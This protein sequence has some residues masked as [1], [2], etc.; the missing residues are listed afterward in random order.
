M[1]KGH[2]ET[3]KSYTPVRS[4][5]TESG[6][7]ESKSKEIVM[8]SWKHDKI[9]FRYSLLKFALITILVIIYFAYSL[10]FFLDPVKNSITKSS[11]ERA[12]EY[13]IPF[14][15]FYAGEGLYNFDVLYVKNGNKTYKYADIFEWNK[16]TD[17]L[18]TYDSSYTQWTIVKI[19]DWEI[20][21]V[22]PYNSTLKFGEILQFAVTSYQPLSPLQ[23]D[24]NNATYYNNATNTSVKTTQIA[25]S[26]VNQ[27]SIEKHQQLL[28]LLFDGG[29]YGIFWIAE[30]TDYLI[31]GINRQNIISGSKYNRDNLQFSFVSGENAV[32]LSL[33]REEN[34]IEYT[35]DFFYDTKSVAWLY[36]QNYTSISTTTINGTSM[37]AYEYENSF[38]FYISP[39]GGGVVQVITTSPLQSF[40]D[41]LAKVGGLWAPI[42][43]VLTILF[44]LLLIKNIGSC[45]G[46]AKHRGL[47]DNMK[48]QVGLYYKNWDLLLNKI[49]MKLYDIKN[50]ELNNNPDS[51]IFICHLKSVCC[52]H[53]FAKYITAK[54][55]IIN[56]L[57]LLTFSLFIHVRRKKK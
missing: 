3:T 29:V 54:K 4:S 39:R 7:I 34:E 31:D 51:C 16:N 56:A 28:S 26:L 13:K 18:F 38:K 32:Q 17:G 15:Y 27:S 19:S 57:I 52:I 33:T 5:N 44:G 9:A 25:P 35:Q 1:K 46:C 12:T 49:L 50:K 2:M 10:I 21:L 23:F 22:P 24:D 42:N 8:E 47:N 37:V 48:H 20:L 30:A 53:F 41:M 6:N 40:W 14:Y 11:V 36:N 43:T 45:F 55:L